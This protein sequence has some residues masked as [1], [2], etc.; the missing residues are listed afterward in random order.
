MLPKRIDDPS[1]VFSFRAQTCSNGISPDIIH[2]QRE[3]FTALIVA[4]SMIKVAVLPNDIVL[5][6][7]KALPIPNGLAHCFARRERE[8][9]VHM[10]G[11]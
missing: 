9:C 1:P 6:G 3:L 11:H 10:I 8:K 7:V 2:F 5:P 4:Q